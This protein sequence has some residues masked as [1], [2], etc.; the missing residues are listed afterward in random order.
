M[1]GAP[2]LDFAFAGAPALKPPP[3][4]QRDLRF[5]I[6]AF[7]VAVALHAAALIA[8]MSHRAASPAAPA[9]MIAELAP[10]ADVNES[11]KPAA[12][13]PE[14]A[15][16]AAPPVPVQSTLQPAPQRAQP[17]PEPQPEPPQALPE[18]EPQPEPPPVI[19][20]RSETTPAP[21]VPAPRPRPKA[22]EPVPAP[23]PLPPPA[24]PTPER[25]T[26]DYS[27]WSALNPDQQPPQEGQRH[28]TQPPSEYLPRVYEQIERYKLYPRM[29]RARHIEGEVRLFFVIDRSGKLIKH[30]IERSSGSDILDSAVDDLVRRVS[31]FP[32]FPESMPDKQLEITMTVTFYLR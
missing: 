2:R 28:A 24:P 21:N 15:T 32:P 11:P 29:A 25:S 13:K 31:P 10:L 7:V 9:A 1:T 22:S 8:L 17:E 18:P 16:T 19:G 4:D 6:A 3:Q 20:S 26:P 27:A 14:P 30:R 23:E 12:P 5:W